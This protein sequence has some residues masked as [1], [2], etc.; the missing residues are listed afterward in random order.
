MSRI[1]RQ[2]IAVPSGVT[3][4]MDNGVF[5]VKGPK[6][7]LSVP[8]NTELTIKKDGDNLVVE[9]PSDQQRHRALHGLTRTLVANAVKGVSDGYTINLELKGVGFRAKM[10]GK[11]LEMA[12]GFSHPDQQ[13][14]RPDPVSQIGVLEGQMHDQEA[15]PCADGQ[16]QLGTPL[17]AQRGVERPPA[18]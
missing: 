14:Q 15:E 11:N 1:G 10:A 7:E 6:G 13:S 16:P 5:K 17:L 8:Y 18:L 9:R 3:V 4:N 2:P 12:M